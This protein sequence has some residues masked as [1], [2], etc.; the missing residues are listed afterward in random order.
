MQNSLFSACQAG[1]SSIT[2]S[3]PQLQAV[4]LLLAAHEAGR[5]VGR[6]AE[7]MR[8]RVTAAAVTPTSAPTGR[9]ATHRLLWGRD[10]S[11][12]DARQPIDTQE[13]ATQA[14]GDSDRDGPAGRVSYIETVSVR[15]W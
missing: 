9:G 3:Q 7:G 6:T 10:I 13:E 14:F 8:P 5:A 15:R 4:E 2:K 11:V 12:H 1:E